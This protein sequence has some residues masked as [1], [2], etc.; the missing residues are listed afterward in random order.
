MVQTRGKMLGGEGGSQPGR[1]TEEGRGAHLAGL[2][3]SYHHVITVG[4][5]SASW[6][7]LFFQRK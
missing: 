1:S 6:G 7:E 5:C 2:A 3:C 4:S